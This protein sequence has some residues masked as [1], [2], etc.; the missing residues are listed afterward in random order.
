MLKASVFRASA[1]RLVLRSNCLRPPAGT[2]SEG[3]DGRSTREE[4]FQ[5]LK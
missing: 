1:P 4:E 3:R 2:I 5:E